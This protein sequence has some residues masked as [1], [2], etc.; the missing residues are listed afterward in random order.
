MSM[1]D[2]AIAKSCST[3]LPLPSL[4]HGV[5]FSGLFLLTTTIMLHFEELFR[6]I[7]YLVGSHE[8]C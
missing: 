6:C 4:F 7:G 5:A 1:A 3:L 8:R 2:C